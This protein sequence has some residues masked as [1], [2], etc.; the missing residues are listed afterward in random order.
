MKKEEFLKYLKTS[1]LVLISALSVLS[2]QALATEVQSI[3]KK[4]D[5]KK[6]LQLSLEPH[7]EN[8]VL[9]ITWGSKLPGQNEKEFKFQFSLKQRF[10]D[11]DFF[12]GYT[13]K[14]FWQIYDAGNSRPFRESNYNPELFWDKCFKKVGN[15][16]FC[17]VVG[18][19]EHESNGMSSTASRS[20]NRT[21]I[22][23]YYI[24]ENEAG[25]QRLRVDLKVW[26]RWQE[27]AKKD[28]S[29]PVGDDNPDLSDYYG[30]SE[31]KAK[32]IYSS[33]YELML[34]GRWNPK[35]SKGAFEANLVTPMPFIPW[36]N[37]HIIFQYWSGYGESLLNYN[38]NL[39][40]YGVGLIF[41]KF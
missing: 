14:S 9:P 30:F 39:T 24:W 26:H 10:G 20:W 3:E 21:Y 41:G 28:P 17:G 27:D 40:R 36:E 32:Y 12:F 22:T 25:I 33:D 15:H 5:K 23:P 37:M 35:T 4:E 29:D 16:R 13:Q 31:L 34:L 19:F 2:L 38:K 8:Y 11:S 7:K 18:V 6:T 1:S